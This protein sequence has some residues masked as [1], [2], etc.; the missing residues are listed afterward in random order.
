V[1]QLAEHLDRVEAECFTAPRTIWRGRHTMLANA[2]YEHA[3]RSESAVKARDRGLVG[4]ECW[5]NESRNLR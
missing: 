4:E 3:Q 2:L 5:L 1:Q